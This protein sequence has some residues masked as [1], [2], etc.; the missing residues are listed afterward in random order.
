MIYLIKGKTMK[1][2]EKYMPEVGEDLSG[3]ITPQVVEIDEE[4]DQ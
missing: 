1:N 3:A 2:E 4:Q